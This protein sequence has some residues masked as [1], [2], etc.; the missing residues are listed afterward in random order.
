MSDKHTVTVFAS[1]TNP[2]D[3][4]R[5]L[6]DA[7]SELSGPVAGDET[8]DHARLLGQ[9]LVLDIRPKDAGVEITVSW[10]PAP[11]DEQTHG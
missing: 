9:K 8:P 10:R 4:G 1:S 3:W 5:A 11:R 7:M 2:K 6:A